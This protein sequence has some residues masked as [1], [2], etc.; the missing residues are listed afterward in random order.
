MTH[1]DDD[2]LAQYAFDPEGVPDRETIE[3]HLRDCPSCT[4]QLAFIRTIDSGLKDEESW[5]IA[6]SIGVGLDVSRLVELAGRVDAE[7]AEA[8]ALLTP[9]LE[10][11]LRFVWADIAR[12]ER[13]RSPGVVRVLCRAALAACEKHP[14]HALDLANAAV[15][16]AEEL[17]DDLYP[18][19]AVFGLR[20]LAWKDRA[21]A[22]RYLGRY[23]EALVSLDEAT[24]AY[25]KLR[26]NAL[27]LAVVDFVR[28]TVLMSG[29]QFE[30]SLVS[31]RRCA[32][33]FREYQEEA[34]YRHARLLE[35]SILFMM[36]D[37]RGARPILTDI[38][39]LAERH[40]DR[41]LTAR[42]AH[43]LGLVEMEMGDSSLA[44]KHL[45][46]ALALYT[47]LGVATEAIRTRWSLARLAAARGDFDDALRRFDAV[48]DEFR[49]Q[50]IIVDEALVALDMADLLLTTGD[51]TTAG[52]IASELFG[53]FR[54]AGM[55]TS[56]LTA[57]GFLN[58]A[59][60]HGR[61]TPHLVRHVR[62]FLERIQRQPGLLFAPP[63]D[64][65][66]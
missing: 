17:P 48:R 23:G 47:D 9:L 55:M 45:S 36:R 39:D 13:Y 58:E 18:S 6:N 2:E 53:T 35:A 63:H 31:V 7:D 60:A 8:E 24:A 29:D 28:A 43:N 5:D 12:K 59:A 64:E 20:G 66:G 34:R 52:A 44:E 46:T 15:S 22:L 40:A 41:M 51:P 25:Q 65:V 49:W 4:S 54:K 14:L 50:G 56:A 21:N 10:S 11:P 57:I 61:L 19:Q 32:P 26:A 30:E 16:I 27:E 1:Y 42:A 37:M 62:G 3:A 38:L 33:V